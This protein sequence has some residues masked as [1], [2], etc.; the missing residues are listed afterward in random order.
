MAKS[1]ITAQSRLQ[2]RELVYIEAQSMYILKVTINFRESD[3]GKMCTCRVT[4]TGHWQPYFGMFLRKCFQGPSSNMV[5]LLASFLSILVLPYWFHRLINVKHQKLVSLIVV[6]KGFKNSG[7]CASEQRLYQ[8][9][10]VAA[11][12]EKKTLLI[13]NQHTWFPKGHLPCM[14]TFNL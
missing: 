2:I 1:Q 9:V 8:L 14:Y 13:K 10:P 11:S 12:W 3:S 4:M 7:T 6:R 5:L